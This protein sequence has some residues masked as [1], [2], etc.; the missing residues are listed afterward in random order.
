MTLHAATRTPFDHPITTGSVVESD[1]ITAPVSRLTQV[2]RRRIVAVIDPVWPEG[3]DDHSRAPLPVVE[4]AAELL[5]ARLQP[6]ELVSATPEGRLLLQLRREDRAARPVRLQEMAYFA[7]EVLDRLHR[8]G[9]FADLGVGWAPITRQQDPTAAAEAATEAASE[10]LRQRDLQPR[11]DGAHVKS[12]N[13]RISW[14]SASRQVVWATL[15]SVFVPFLLMVGLYR[16]GIDVSGPLY[17]TL[18]GALSLTALTIW[19]EVSHAFTPPR[20]PPAP[21]QDAPQ[22]TAIIAAYLPNEADT[23]E[24]TLEHFVHH[25]YSGD[26]QVVLAYNSPVPLPVEER[27]AALDR[28]HERLTVLKVEDSTSKAQNVNSA[29]RIA[30]GEFVGIFDADH[31][32]ADGSFDRAWRWIAAGHDVVQGHCVIRNGDDSALAKLVAVEFEQIYAV[33]HPGRAAFSGFGIFGGSNGYWRATALERIRLRGS[34]LTEDIEASMRTLGAGGSLVSDPGLV[35]YELAPENVRSLWKQRL[36][37]AQ[38]WFQVSVRHLWTLLKRPHLTLRQK[39]GLVYLLGWR[40]VYPWVSMFA[41]P[42]LMFLAWRDGGLRMTSPLFVLITLF[43]TVSGPLQTLAAYR[44]AAPAIRRHRSW[45]MW[46]CLANLL[47]YTEAKNL[48]NR[49]AHLKQLRGEH[50]WVV[51]PRTAASHG[52]SPTDPDSD[53]TDSDPTDSDQ[54]MEVAA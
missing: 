48:V 53:P 28:A 34:F 17:W 49:V 33:A 36:R 1:D 45:F 5:T 10:S 16:L 19:A 40:E 20:V 26:L 15:G 7:L 29:L 47:V 44:L 14:F 25:D 12:R 30:T 6:G 18:V 42:L 38:G 24:E 31:H 23:I 22:A 46:S 8:T 4:R 2:A 52:S 13:P 11:Q 37:W 43:V 41:W 21:E 35:S 54:R 9:G 39:V 51:T 3:E 32:P 27:L 50:Q